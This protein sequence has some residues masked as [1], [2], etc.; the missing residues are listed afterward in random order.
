MIIL[1]KI[2]LQIIKSV[3][4]NPVRDFISYNQNLV[5]F[6]INLLGE[7]DTFQDITCRV[8]Q[9]ALKVYLS[10]WHFQLPHHC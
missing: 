6:C 5:P 9:G 1:I 10:P 2:L 3:S 7:Q 8:G 4:L